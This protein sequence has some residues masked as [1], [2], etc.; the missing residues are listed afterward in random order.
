M[1]LPYIYDT[2]SSRIKKVYRALVCAR[3]DVTAVLHDTVLM[4]GGYLRTF[5]LPTDS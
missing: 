4:I 3:T 5:S 2:E 1:G